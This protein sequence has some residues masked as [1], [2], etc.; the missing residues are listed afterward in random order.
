MPLQISAVSESLVVSASQVEIPLSRVV[1]RHGHLGRGAAGAAG[2]DGHRGV[3]ARARADG[4]AIGRPGIAHGDLSAR[5]RVGL[6]PRASRRHRAECVRRR[7]RSRASL[8]RTNIDRIEVVRGPQ[9]ALYGSNAIGAVVRI[10][11]RSGGPV[12]G[13]A[14]IEAG[15][16]GTS[17]RCRQFRRSGRPVV[18][19]CRRVIRLSSD[20]CNGRTTS[21]GE[22]VENDRVRANR[23]GRQRRLAQ[24]RG[25]DGAGRDAVRTRRP[26]LPRSVRIQSCRQLH[27]CRHDI[28]RHA[29]T[30]GAPHSVQRCRWAHASARTGRSRG[31]RATA[32]S[33]PRHRFRR[34]DRACRTPGRAALSARAQ[35]DISVRAGLDVSARPRASAREGDEHLHRR[36]QRTDSGEAARRRLFRRSPV[37]PVRAVF[38]TGGVR[39]EDIGRDA[40][41]PL[42]DPFSPRP[43]MP[44]DSS[45]R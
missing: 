42:N 20:G 31:T 5:R 7:F 45:C 33:S 30:D 25:R 34:Q 28:A 27:R 21:A 17:S 23:R 40:V 10:V 38:V 3:A 14:S 12:R 24:C 39:L 11:T 18:L 35:T 41:A 9:S 43:A 36:R 6:H 8:R 16:F 26:R 13:D 37:E 1:R 44:A 19:G 32:S 22:R 2:D 15:T 4:C 29:T